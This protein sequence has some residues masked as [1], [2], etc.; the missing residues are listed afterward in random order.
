MSKKRKKKKKTKRGS[1]S[2]ISLSS[3]PKLLCLSPATFF[4]MDFYGIRSF[5]HQQ[6]RNEH[7]SLTQVCSNILWK[8]LFGTFTDNSMITLS[9]STT[10]IL[11]IAYR[12]LLTFNAQKNTFTEENSS[13]HYTVLTF[14]MI[15]LFWC[16]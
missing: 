9:A 2:V 4:P 5:K 12:N 6:H 3:H 14:H 8:F 10:S 11:Q 16:K 1:I 13:V 15:S 7:V